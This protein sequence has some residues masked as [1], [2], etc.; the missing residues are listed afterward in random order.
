MHAQL[1]SFQWY[2][3]MQGLIDTI[4]HNPKLDL[5]MKEEILSVVNAL[6]PVFVEP[7]ALCINARLQAP[8]G[9]DEYAKAMFELEAAIWG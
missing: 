2:T 8:T 1:T 5:T 6:S 4:G 3:V 9:S 7:F